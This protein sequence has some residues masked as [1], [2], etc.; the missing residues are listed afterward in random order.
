MWNLTKQ[1]SGCSPMLHFTQQY[2]VH[3]PHEPQRRCVPCLSTRWPMPSK[4]I[5]GRISDFFLGFTPLCEGTCV[6][7][8]TASV[9]RRT[10]SSN[11]TPGAVFLYNSHMLTIAPFRQNGPIPFSRS[12][13]NADAGQTNQPR[14][15]PCYTSV[16]CCTETL[17]FSLPLHR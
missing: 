15:C 16:G 13:T 17:F 4:R 11:G 9:I 1:L 6:Y 3:F 10:N 8:R 12:D 2:L 5:S 14:P 7:V